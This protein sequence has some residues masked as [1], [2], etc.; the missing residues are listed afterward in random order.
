MAG[1]VPTAIRLIQASAGLIRLGEVTEVKWDQAAR[2]TATH[3]KR[4]AE[5][6]EDGLKGFGIDEAGASPLASP[7]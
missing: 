5:A 6:V 7:R 1:I 2:A 3:L 4:L